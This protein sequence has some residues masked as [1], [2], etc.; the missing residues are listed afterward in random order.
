MMRHFPR[1]G[2]GAAA[3]A[4][5]AVIGAEAA[6][7]AQSP[8]R[9]P[10][11]APPVAAA[12]TNAARDP[13][14]V[15]IDGN[16]VN[17]KRTQ[18]GTVATATGNVVIWYRDTTLRTDAATYN[19]DTQI[20]NSPGKLQ[21]DDAQNTVI[22]DKGVAYYKKRTAIVTGNVRITARPRPQDARAPQGS[23]RREFKDPVLI[24]CDR[25][26]YNWRTRVANAVDSLTVKFTL[27]ERL[28]TVTAQRALYDG[29][30]ETVTLTGAVRGANEAGEEVN[31]DSAV[32]VLR[33]GAESLTMES[34]KSL[35]FRVDTADEE[36]EP[37][38]P[39]TPPAAPPAA[40]TLPPP[41]GVRR[42]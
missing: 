5:L 41:G 22:G 7:R 33:E 18:K 32:I 23:P 4:A 1:P 29:R 10:P 42:P 21:V 40:P 24:T 8:A 16:L 3:L 28:W 26:E 38:P 39:V 37:L 12:G 13:N 35:K 20:A 34:P 27:R 30:A 2:I 6:L 17:S 14:Y 15:Y 9:K 31:A 19:D 25:V 11:P 36:D